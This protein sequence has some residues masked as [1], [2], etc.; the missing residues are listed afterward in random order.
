MNLHHAPARQRGFNLTELLVVVVIV[1]VLAAIGLP[2]Y[3]DY[4]LTNKRSDA[5][6]GLMRMSQLQERF[7]TER[8][9]YANNATLMGYGGNTPASAGGFWTLSVAAASQT[10]FTVQAA[11]LLPHVDPQCA[12]ITLNAAGIRA[13]TPGP[14]DCWAGR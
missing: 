3:R 10:A 2:A 12:T 9:R 8:G 14:E 11:P 7:F 13:S 1:G 5:Q 4:A 6:A